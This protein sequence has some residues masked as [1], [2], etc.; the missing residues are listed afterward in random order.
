MKQILLASNNSG[1]QK[2]FL[3]FFK[4]TNFEL[5]TPKMI[6]L[7]LDI[8]ETGSTFE[9]NASLKS[10][11]FFQATRI[12]TIADDSG[13][14]VEALDGQ[15]GVYSARYGQKNMTEKERA[16]YLLSNI[17]SIKNRNAYFYCV[18]AYT[19]ENETKFF[20]GQTDGQILMDYDPGSYGFGYDPIFYSLDLNKRFSYCL[21]EEKIL[22]SHRGRAIQKFIDYIV[23][24]TMRKI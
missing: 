5:V 4:S 22:V 11:A 7:K 16:E 2:E 19:N 23:K 10:N 8:E 20:S 3:S 6:E 9:Q 12:P 21:P 24:D 17:S 1:K 13:L 14:C 15:P 18:I